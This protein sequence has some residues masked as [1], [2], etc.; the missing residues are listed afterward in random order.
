MNSATRITVH[1][2]WASKTVHATVSL[3]KMVQVSV[4]N[5]LN[6]ICNVKEL[7]KD[8]VCNNWL[9]QVSPFYTLFTLGGRTENTQSVKKWIWSQSKKG[10]ENDKNPRSTLFPTALIQTK[11]SMRE[12]YNHSQNLFFKKKDYQGGRLFKYMLQLMMLPIVSGKMW[13]L[14]YKKG[15]LISNSAPTDVVTTL[16]IS[17]SST[18]LKSKSLS[19]P[20]SQIRRVQDGYPPPSSK[21]ELQNWSSSEGACIENSVRQQSLLLL[22]LARHQSQARNV[23]HVHLSCNVQRNAPGISRSSQQPLPPQPRHI[24]P[25]FPL[26]PV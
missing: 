5:F 26:P 24:Q 13:C 22:M 1:W 23:S 6:K 20:W 25:W 11:A 14:C 18:P 16:G 15:A 21:K 17:F 7:A 19:T 12:C 10:P 3:M 9:H 8:I 4:L 2:Q